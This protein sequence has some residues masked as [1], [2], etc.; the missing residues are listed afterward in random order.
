MGT[1]HLE[2]PWDCV[3][4]I[5]KFPICL[6]GYFSI[7][8]MILF[9]DMTPDRYEIT[10]ITKITE[11]IEIKAGIRILKDPFNY[12]REIQIWQSFPFW[13]ARIVQKILQGQHQNGISRRLPT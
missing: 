6:C 4:L 13:S 7:Y 2:S 12:R 5:S 10:A 11:I 3:S 8:M 9:F 1:I